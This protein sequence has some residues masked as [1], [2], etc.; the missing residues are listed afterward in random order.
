MVIAS[1][2]SY[3]LNEVIAKSQHENVD[4]MNYEAR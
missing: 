1:G 2:V 3:L 4:H